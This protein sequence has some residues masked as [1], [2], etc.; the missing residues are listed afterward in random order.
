MQR[1]LAAILAVALLAGCGTPSQRPL[2]VAGS[3]QVMHIA[4]I[5][6]E[7]YAR[8]GGGQISV[9]G[10]GSTLGVLAVLDGI[11]EIGAISRELTPEETSRGLVA[12]RIAYDAQAVV[13]H[14]SNPVASLSLAQLR[15]IYVGE[16]KD[17]RE[18][19]GRPGPILLISREAGSGAREIFRRAVGPVAPESAV[20]P[21]H[22]IA[23]LYVEMLPQAIGYVGLRVA[24]NSRVTVVAIDG[25]RP[26][27]PGYPLMQPLSLVTRGEPQGRAADFIRFALSPEGQRLAAEEGLVPVREGSSRGW[28]GAMGADSL[29]VR[30]AVRLGQRGPDRAHAGPGG[31]AGD[32]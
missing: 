16:V 22:G 24:R 28:G 31:L 30:G 32:P 3:A 2:T 19:G 11:A 23:A 5:W 27:D 7:A 13:V 1:W 17:W 4:G 20:V 18:V 29:A 25:R 9:N 12:H 15:R 6:A 14:P 10:G 26:G 8:G 21:A